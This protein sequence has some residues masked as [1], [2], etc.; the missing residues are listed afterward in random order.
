MKASNDE[1][2]PGAIYLVE[3]CSGERRPWRYFGPPGAENPRWQD[4]ETAREF[5]EA[6]VLYAWK[7]IRRLD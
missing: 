7:I 5:G 3:L 1:P 4:V 6:S 2:T